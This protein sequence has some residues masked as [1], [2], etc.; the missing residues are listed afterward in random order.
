MNT[1][2]AIYDLNKPEKD[3]PKLIAALEKYNYFHCLD[4]TWILRTE[5]TAAQVMAQLK[6]LRDSNDE[7]I[8][9]DVT[10]DW[11]TWIG[12]SDQCSNWLKENF[13]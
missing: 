2:I 13:K 9:I 3:Y 1:L 8:V 4:S 11:V 5:E 6:S 7:L 12:F 10:G